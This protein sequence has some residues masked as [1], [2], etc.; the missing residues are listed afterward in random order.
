[1]DVHNMHPPLLRKTNPDLQ[2]KPGIPLFIRS[3]SPEAQQKQRLQLGNLIRLPVRVVYGSIPAMEQ[4]FGA[5]ACLKACFC[6]GDIWTETDTN[7]E[8]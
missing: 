7:E 1:M 4:D 2:P 6:E 8:H 5:V 3:T